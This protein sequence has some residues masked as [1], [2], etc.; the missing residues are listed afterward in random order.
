MTAI[1]LPARLALTEAEDTLAEVRLRLGQDAPIVLDASEVERVS[2]AG[3]Q[4]L[5][6]IATNTAHAPGF[7][8]VNPSETFSAAMARLGLEA[9]FGG[10]A[11]H[12]DP[13]P[14]LDAPSEISLEIADEADGAAAG[15]PS[16]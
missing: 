15:D 8:L 2:A 13:A 1:A 5:A 14:D 9:L 16:L 7:A 11:A 6:A 12:A 3:A 10:D 4:T